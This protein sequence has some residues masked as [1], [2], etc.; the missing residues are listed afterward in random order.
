MSL[1]FPLFYF[2]SAYIKVF[3]MTFD[4]IE[5]IEIRRFKTGPLSQVFNFSPKTQSKKETNSSCI[6]T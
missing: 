6:T 3:P 4:F 1:K 5:K 2:K